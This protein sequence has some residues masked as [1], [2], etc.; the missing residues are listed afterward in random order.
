MQIT[1]FLSILFFVS[2]LVVGCSDD[3]ENNFVLDTETGNT[4][5]LGTSANDLLSDTNFRGLTVE[6]ISVEGFAP[7]TTAINSFR[8][9]LEDRLN[10]PDGITINQ[11]T[12][13]S[14]GLAPFNISKIRQIETVERTLFNEGDEITVYI[15]FADGSNE[16]DNNSKVILG[17]AYLNTSIVIYE[18]TLRE[19]SSNPLAPMLS[20]IEAATLNHEFSHLL[21]LVN[22][23]TPLQSPH[24]DSLS[25]GH[26]SSENCLMRAAI[27][28]ESG[29]MDLM[30]NGVPTLCPICLADLRANG[31]K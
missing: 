20:T 1:K 19:L 18:K 28:F 31:G 22:I 6:I 27:E 17:S 10:K 15:Y 4:K 5:A 23:G 9:F 8:N 11:R 13:P 25:L 29:M 7:T 12:V 26:C 24:E 2:F 14:S 3:D 16:T 21:G 30:G